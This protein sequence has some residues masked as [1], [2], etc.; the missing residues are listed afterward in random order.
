MTI[1][2]K[3]ARVNAGYTQ[4]T[5][6]KLLNISNK[7]LCAWENGRSYPNAKKIKDICA[8]YGMSYDEILFLTYNPY[9]TDYREGGWF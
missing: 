5:A 1:T 8:L 4:K 3:A 9:I 7:T 2:L 6:A